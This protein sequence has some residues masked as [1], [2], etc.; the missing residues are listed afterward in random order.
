MIGDLRTGALVDRG[1]SIA[2][3]C[4][5]RF[6]SGALFASILG[7]ERNG[8]WRLAPRGHASVQRTYCGDTLVLTTTFTQGDARA[9]ATDFMPLDAEHP[10]IVRIVEGL[11]G[12]VGFDM[13]LAPRMH[14][15]QLT[16]AGRLR[17][18]RWVASIGPDAVALRSSAPLEEVAGGCR[19]H[20]S[21]A[22][23]ERAEFVLQWFPAHDEVPPPC[24][25][26]RAE[27]QTLRWWQGWAAALRYEGPWRD[28]VVRSAIMLK[29]LTD[30]ATGGM[31]AA[32][33]TSLPEQIGSSKNWDYR[34]CW[35]RDA[36]FA[37]TSLLKVGA[38][39]EARAFRDWFMRVCGPD[40]DQLHIMYGIGG[41]RL[42]PEYT[43]P[44]LTGFNDSRPVRVG[45]GA[46]DQF[47]LGVIGD[48]LWN[49][50]EAAAAGIPFDA[51]HWATLAPLGNY[52]QAR[53]HAP[54]NG[55]WETRDGR[56]QY[57]DSKV[58]AWVAATKLGE[59]ASACGRPD[60][61]ARFGPLA[62]KIH[63]QVER[64]G[65]DP[66]QAAFTQYYGSTELDA[67]LLLMPITGFLPYDDPRV[68]GTIRAI[69]SALMRDGFVYRYSKDIHAKNGDPFEGEGAFT[70][71]GFWLVQT[72]AQSGRL[73][74]AVELFERLLS[75]ANDVGLLSEEYDVT[76][77]EAIGN[78]PQAFSHSGLIDA[79]LC[80]S[81]ALQRRTDDGT[82]EGIPWHGEEIST[83]TATP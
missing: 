42:A 32:L 8:Y 76:R 55:I 51:D 14:Y 4:T 75:T 36:S 60:E 3:W 67:S 82:S 52:I 77:R 10:T 13:D 48:V 79:A 40:A 29:A 56:R 81:Q 31:V 69:E 34:Y 25:A 49:F 35:L 59:L 38:T 21:L 80:L 37:A 16:P 12:S 61:S 50:S 15:G 73:A 23:G 72:L 43:L 2:W 70:M 58:L 20:F 24:D 46:H 78:V 7:D 6:D 64:A 83:A 53:W 5:P 26:R 27:Q 62:A 11:A 63:A 45:N 33:T 66:E 54:G 28:Q 1:G 74:A 17:G 57:V 44:W 22:A 19:A 47:Q 18:C 39:E 65:F 9:Q 30:R 71:C 41:E 68:Q